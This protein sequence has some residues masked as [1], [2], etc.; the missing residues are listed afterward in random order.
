MNMYY[1]YPTIMYEI[2]SAKMC[3]FMIK[4]HRYLPYLLKQVGIVGQA[5]FDNTT[6]MDTNFPFIHC[7]RIPYA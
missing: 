5:S 6:R 4:K 3:V 2:S 1:G 7:S